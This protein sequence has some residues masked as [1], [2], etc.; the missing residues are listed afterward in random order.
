MHFRMKKCSLSSEDN[1]KRKR[2]F[3]FLKSCTVKQTCVLCNNHFNNKLNNVDG[4]GGQT[5]LEVKG[6]LR[7]S[8]R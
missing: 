3:C 8:E 2:G 6:Y 1:L 4:I 7:Y 5:S